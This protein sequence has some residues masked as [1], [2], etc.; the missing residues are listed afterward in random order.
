[1]TKASGNHI[2]Q[3][4]MQID[5]SCTKA[6]YETK[7]Q[8]LYIPMNT[9]LILAVL[10]ASFFI[11]SGSL[12]ATDEHPGPPQ[13]QPLVV[14]D[15]EVF[16]GVKKYIYTYAQKSADK[17]FHIQSGGKDVALDLIAIHADRLSDLGG[18]KHFVCVDMKA[19]NGA[20]YDIDF[21]IT[22]RSGTLS[23]TEASVHKINGKPLYNWKE[24][25]G[26]LRKVK[27]S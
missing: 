5:M 6:A 16:A 21:F 19:A 27:V 8:Q 26:I 13:Q 25:N 17:K 15:A 14:S 22:V 20:T 10:V 23:V 12:L 1:M 7:V 3:S 11:I 18:N 9:P 2:E 24:Q 4:S